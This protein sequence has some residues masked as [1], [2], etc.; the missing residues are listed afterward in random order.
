MKKIFYT[1]AFL[2]LALVSC[3]KDDD[4]LLPDP[5]PDNPFTEIT[6]MYFNSPE[7]KFNAD[8]YWADY[9]RNENLH[10]YGFRFNHYLTVYDTVEGFI[11][12]KNQDTREFDP[13]YEHPYT[14]M[15]GGGVNGVGT[16]YLVATYATN[17]NPSNPSLRITNN[18]FMP[19]APQS[20]TVNNTT[21]VY[22]T[23]RDGNAF[24]KKFEAGD[25]F[26]LTIHGVQPNGEEKT[27]DF[28]LANC[29][30]SNHPE[31]E[32]VTKWTKVD[33]TPLGKVQSLY[34]TLSSSDN[35][36]WGMNTPG[37]FAMGSFS[38]IM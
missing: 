13:M 17:E 14:V 37:Y 28:M 27:V 38:Y 11:V 34:F 4:D 8:G 33:L 6:T 5:T 2:A 26:K 23:L 24:S 21:Y 10:L 35:S 32:I 31:A 16:P 3:D 19:F 12:S 7:L 9:R 36:E 15:G 22:Y 30:S 25:W 29:T 20:I 18:N 1:F